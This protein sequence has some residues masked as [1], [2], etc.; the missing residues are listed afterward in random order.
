MATTNEGGGNG[1]IYAILVIIV[2]LIVGAIVYFGGIFRPGDSGADIKADV[3]VEAP[4][5][6]ASGNSGS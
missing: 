4:Q 6:P 3:R 2:I 5:P 1:G